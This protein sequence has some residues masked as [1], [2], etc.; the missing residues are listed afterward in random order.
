MAEQYNEIITDLSEKI[1]V[2]ISLYEKTKNDK[3]NL[4][5]KNKELTKDCKTKQ[6]KIEELE[7]KYNNLKVAKSLSSDSGE[8][9]EVKTKINRLVREIDKCIAQLNQ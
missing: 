9:D 6:Q 4:E 7:N 2:I 5:N 8:K 1:N 3:I